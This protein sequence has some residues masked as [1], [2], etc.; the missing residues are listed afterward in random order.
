MDNHKARVINR[1]DAAARACAASAAVAQ[2]NMTEAKRLIGDAD[3]ETVSAMLSAWHWLFGGLHGMFVVEQFNVSFTPDTPDNTE[4]DKRLIDEAWM[5]L[6]SGKDSVPDLCSC[7]A[8]GRNL[9]L[10]LASM[11]AAMLVA[12][13]G[14]ADAVA[15][16]TLLSAGF[17][18]GDAAAPSPASPA[19]SFVERM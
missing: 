6:G 15:H 1:L 16:W 13:Y 12:L 9:A 14:P 10:C 7:D 8:C 5:F 2:E 11:S 17:R 4:F 19:P 18:S 3:Y